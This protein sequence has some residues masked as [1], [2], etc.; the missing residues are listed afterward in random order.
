MRQ[1][2][3]LLLHVNTLLLL[4][5]QN[6]FASITQHVKHNIQDELFMVGRNETNWAQNASPNKSLC[7][8][9]IYSYRKKYRAK[10][11][12]QHIDDYWC[13]KVKKKEVSDLLRLNYFPFVTIMCISITVI[14][15]GTF[16]PHFLKHS[17]WS[18]FIFACFFPLKYTF[19]A[20]ESSVIIIH[21]GEPLSFLCC[22]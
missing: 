4:M 5:L 8:T 9:T 12:K 15:K 16:F 1:M 3:N 18:S 19:Y 10:V 22:I 6:M 2:E 7:V 11:L 14:N 17:K 20:D 13:K 21:M